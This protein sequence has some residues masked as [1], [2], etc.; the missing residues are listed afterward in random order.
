MERLASGDR[1][2]FDE[3]YRGLWPILLRATRRWLGD[4]ADAEDAAQRALVEL[5]GRAHEYDRSASCVAWALTIA[6]WECRTV[7]RRRDR[8]RLAPLAAAGEHAS[9]GESPEAFASRRELEASVHGAL[10]EL[11]DVDRELIEETVFSETG[12]HAA[13]PASARKRKQRAIDRLRTL[14]RRLYGT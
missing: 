5:M 4:H 12:E 14:W 2:A 7:R 8:A 10:G 3:V 6:M 9:P 1:D 13:V 11:S